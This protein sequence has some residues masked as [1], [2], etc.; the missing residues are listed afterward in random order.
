MNHHFNA[1]AVILTVSFALYGVFSPITEP[2][3]IFKDNTASIYTRRM[4]S[5]A[6]RRLP[7][8]FLSPLLHVFLICVIYIKFIPVFMGLNNHLSMWAFQEVTP[9]LRPSARCLPFRT[10]LKAF[11]SSKG[12]KVQIYSSSSVLLLFIFPHLSSQQHFEQ[13]QIHAWAEGSSQTTS[14]RS[15]FTQQDAAPSGRASKTFALFSSGA[16]QNRYHTPPI[17]GQVQPAARRLPQVSA[18]DRHPAEDSRGGQ[19]SAGR[20]APQ[21]AAVRTSA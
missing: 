2:S 13:H 15:D 18:G 19:A 14:E 11:L 10:S 5:S 7:H 1:F 3:L 17:C 9:L 16:A 8:C 4:E 6:R 20:A 12:S 21:A